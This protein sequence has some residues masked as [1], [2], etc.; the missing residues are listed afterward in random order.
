MEEKDLNFVS[1][2]NQIL[3]ILIRSKQEG[4]S[5]GILSNRLGPATLITCVDDIVFDELQTI[6][7]LKPF[8]HTGYML[9]ANRLDLHDITYVCPLN[10]EFRNPYLDNITKERNWFF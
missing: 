1:N 8:D 5:V 10:S 7:I 4:R 9:P 6:I 3:E 2:R